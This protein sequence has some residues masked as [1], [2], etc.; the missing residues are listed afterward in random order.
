MLVFVIC[1]IKVWRSES[2]PFCFKD[3]R[4]SPKLRIDKSGSV[5]YFRALMLPLAK[6]I[7]NQWFKQAKPGI[8]CQRISKCHSGQLSWGEGV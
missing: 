5:I 1:C 8:I 2:L 3:G 6:M 4:N 7:V